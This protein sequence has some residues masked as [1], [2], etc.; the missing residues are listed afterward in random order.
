MSR[1][2]PQASESHAVLVAEV[3][4]QRELIGMLRAAL[5]VQNQ[6]TNPYSGIIVRAALEKTKDYAPASFAAQ[7]D[8]H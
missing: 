5:V 2:L 7:S 3:V 4:R 8:T 1:H 6:N